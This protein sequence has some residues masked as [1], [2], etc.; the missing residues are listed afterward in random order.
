MNIKLCSID[1]LKKSNSIKELSVSA[2][3]ETLE[4]LMIYSNGNIIIMENSCPHEKI[5][6][7]ENSVI[8][9][10]DNSIECVNHGAKFN[11]TSGAPLNFVTNRKLKL[12]KNYIDEYGNIYLTIL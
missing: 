11:L 5:P 7:Y 9:E 12:Y 6:L 3:E 4:L 1:D 2:G 10:E 8:A